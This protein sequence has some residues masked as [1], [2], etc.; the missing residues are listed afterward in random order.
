MRMMSLAGIS[1]S[2]SA[3][4]G[5][6]CFTCSVSRSKPMVLAATNSWLWRFSLMITWIIARM[7]A[8]S[9]PGLMG[10]HSSALAAVTV[11]RGSR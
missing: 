3:H 2:F 7:N 6:Y 5:V 10:Y 1:V 8:R 4:S 11:K 9:V